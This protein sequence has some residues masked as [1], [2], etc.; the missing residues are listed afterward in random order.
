MKFKTL[1]FKKRDIDGSIIFAK[2]DKQ[3]GTGRHLAYISGLPEFYGEDIELEGLK[4]Y[5]D[6]NTIH[7]IDFEK[8]ELVDVE[9]KIKV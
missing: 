1:I 7:S 5:F 4:E 2:I 3:E 9:L 8:L 6:N